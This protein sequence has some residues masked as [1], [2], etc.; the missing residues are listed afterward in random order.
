MMMMMMMVTMIAVI[1]QASAIS[2]RIIKCN[3]G[4][5]HTQVH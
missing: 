3:Q 1:K 5:S 2:A 4:E